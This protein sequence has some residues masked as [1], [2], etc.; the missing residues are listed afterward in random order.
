VTGRLAVDAGAARP[1][2]QRREA[3]AVYHDGNFDSV[4]QDR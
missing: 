3:T 1:R 2:L 4:S